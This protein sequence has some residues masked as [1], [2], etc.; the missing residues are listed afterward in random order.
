LAVRVLQLLGSLDMGGAETMVMNVYRHLDRELLRFDFALNNSGVGYYEKEVTDN[1][2][3]I[4]HITPRSVSLK[5]HFEGLYRIVKDNRY[6]ILHYHTENAFLACCD[7]LVCWAAGAKKIVVHSHS[8]MDFRGGRMV[9]LSGLFRLPLRALTD[10]RVSCG[11]DAARWMFGTEKGVTVI[12]LPVDCAKY[13]FSEE[14]YNSCREEYGLV[15]KKVYAHTGS[16]LKVKNHAFLLDVFYWL[17]SADSSA[18][19]ILMG[20]GEERRAIEEKIAELGL[21]DSV[22]VFGIVSDVYD[23]LIAADAFIFPS[24]FEGFPAAVLEAQA[25]GLPCI[26]SDSITRSIDVTECVEFISLNRKADD[27]AETIL[28]MES[29]NAR[30]R[31]ECNHMVAASYDVTAVVKLFCRVYGIEQK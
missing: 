26:I 24:L 23:K 8:T 4:F 18:Y 6:D 28:R 29:N 5:K 10:V 17:H 2:D 12:P 1:D 13:E 16:F 9:R 25:A 11:T 14:K 27:W 3:R 20:D 22:T 15:G 30:Q 7:L 21:Q 31:I 19:L